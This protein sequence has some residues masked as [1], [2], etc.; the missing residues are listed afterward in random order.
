[1]GRLLARPVCSCGSEMVTSEEGGWT[2]AALEVEIKR[3]EK[4]HV[5]AAPDRWATD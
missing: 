2:C 1:M 4:D 3:L 5:M